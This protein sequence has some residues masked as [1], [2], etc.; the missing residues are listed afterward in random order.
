[1]FTKTLYATV[2]AG[3]TTD[4]L[5]SVTKNVAKVDGFKVTGN[6]ALVSSMKLLYSVEILNTGGDVNDLWVVLTSYGITPGNNLG[7]VWQTAD[8]LN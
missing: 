4:A 2:I 8:A 5:A 3:S 7:S 1:M 6:V